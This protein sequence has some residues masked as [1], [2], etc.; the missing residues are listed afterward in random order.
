MKLTAFVALLMMGFAPLAMAH[1]GHALGSLSAGFWHPLTGWDHLLVMLAVGVWA[2][3]FNQHARWTMPASF[4]GMMAVGMALSLAGIR[5]QGIELMLSASVVVM[6]LLLLLATNLPATLRIGLLMVFAC[7]HGIAHGTELANQQVLL[8]M[9]GMLLATAGLHAAGV[10][11][12]LQQRPIAQRLPAGLAW[13]MVMIG[14][15]WTIA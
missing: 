5:M 3:R 9:L 15:Y 1:P 4:L 2:S 6:G 14:A 8:A 7:L 10:V 13:C 12:G 11:L